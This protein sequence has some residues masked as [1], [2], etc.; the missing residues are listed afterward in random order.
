MSFTKTFRKS[1]KVYEA[2]KNFASCSCSA[3]E[4][5]NNALFSDIAGFAVSVF[6]FFVVGFVCLSGIVGSILLNLIVLL[7]TLLGCKFTR[8]SQSA[9]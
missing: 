6:L 8:K 7:I 9:Y 3:N 4:T 1:N 5:K 2:A